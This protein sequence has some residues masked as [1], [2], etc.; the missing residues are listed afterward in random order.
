MAR[1]YKK[2]FHQIAGSVQRLRNDLLTT[3][4]DAAFN[5]FLYNLKRNLE[6]NN[7]RFDRERFDAAAGGTID[8]NNLTGEPNGPTDTH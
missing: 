4:P 7:P 8:G 3:R 2:D 6:D 5:R 1:L